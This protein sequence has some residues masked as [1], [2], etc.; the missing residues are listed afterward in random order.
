VMNGNSREAELLY[1]RLAKLKPTDPRL[2]T[3]VATSA[4][5]RSGAEAV[6]GELQAISDSDAGIVADLAIVNARIRAQ[7]WDAALKAIEAIQRKQ[8]DKPLPLQLKAQVLVQKQDLAGARQ[9]LNEALAKDPNYLPGVSAL[10]AI[11]LAEKQPEAAKQRFKS[12]LE[13]DR[14]NTAALLS[15]AELARRTQAPPSEV[16]G[17]LQS[18]VETNPQDATARLALLDHHAARGDLRAALGVANAAVTALPDNIELLDR[19][20]R[21]QLRMGEVDQALSSYGKITSQQP[22]AVTGHLGQARAHMANNNPV[23]AQRAIERVLEREPQHLEARVMQVS[24]LATQKRYKEALDFARVL[25]SERKNEAVGYLLE[26]EVESAQG[27]WEQALPA[28]RIAAAKPATGGAQMRLHFSLLK[29][30]K[31]AEAETF[32][33]DW[34]KKHPRDAGM[35][36]Y[37]GDVAQSSQRLDAA[38]ARYRE[39]LAIEPNHALAMNNLA[40]ILLQQKKPGA[41]ALIDKALT[42]LP[43]SPPLLDT[44]AQ[45]LSAGG[46]HDKALTVQAKVVSLAPKSAAYRLALARMQVAAGK[47]G[48]ARKE[49]TRIADDSLTMTEAERQELRTML[50]SLQ[51]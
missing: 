41:Q 30:G 21:I 24:V 20:A 40:M 25:Q 17:Y 23:Q 27:R 45:V 28:L 49:L 29:A 43:D 38:E 2:R 39:L 46:D 47:P 22:K 42:L 32:V 6:L 11:D 48:D 5:N 50:A 13:R 26:A 1:N 19:L 44:Q 34:M 8:P 35:L 9:A 18:A 3:I 4:F 31:A 16:Q 15:L 36:F 14:K 37:L 51:R 33:A 10:A 7:Q 12:L